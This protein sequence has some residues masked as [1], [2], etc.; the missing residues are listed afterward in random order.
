MA[1]NY[2]TEY[3]RYRQYYVNLRRFYQK[4]TVKVSFFVLLSFATV[5]FF[6]ALA[7]RP[8][9]T[10]IGALIRDIEDKKLIDDQLEAKV[11]TLDQAQSLVSSIE[12][13]KELLRAALPE[14]AELG[15]FLQEIEFIAKQYGV[16]VL[17]IRFGGVSL[18]ETS[19][20]KPQTQSIPI[21]VSVGGSFGA[22]KSFLELLEN[23]DR[24]VVITDVHLV[25][26]SSGRQGGTVIAEV[27]GSVHYVPP[28]MIPDAIE[29][30]EEEE[31]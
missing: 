22:V 25:S 28:V 24:I 19:S 4:P 11:N 2:R 14:N 31:L 13:D 1:I 17:E 7:I 5:T 29:E 16:R 18:G 3:Q 27:N 10:T 20:R 30:I 26:N 15:R 6:T 23:L 21:K 8:T 9:I 12:E